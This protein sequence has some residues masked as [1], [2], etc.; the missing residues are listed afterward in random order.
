MLLRFIDCIA[1]KSGQ[2]LDY[3][4]QT[5]LE[6]A[7]EKLVLQYY[8]KSGSAVYIFQKI[9]LAEGRTWDLLVCQLFSLS[10]AA[11]QTTRLLRPN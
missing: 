2:R 3:V 4:N 5:H 6:V 11:P 7:S 10:T 8:R 1:Q 9:V